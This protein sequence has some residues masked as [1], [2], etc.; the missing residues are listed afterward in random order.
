MEVALSTKKD[1]WSNRVE[2]DRTQVQVVAKIVRVGKRKDGAKYTNLF[3]NIKPLWIGDRQG[4]YSPREVSIGISNKDGADVSSTI[5]EIASAEFMSANILMIRYSDGTKF[6][7]TFWSAIQLMTKDDIAAEKSQ[8]ISV[9]TKDDE[10]YDQLPNTIQRKA[11]QQQNTWG[12]GDLVADACYGD[13]PPTQE[14]ETAH[15]E[16]F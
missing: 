14:P 2:L 4:D 8:P 15:I 10:I 7:T 5:R 13:S 1:T 16:D 3:V 9:P 12:V 11:P 6:L